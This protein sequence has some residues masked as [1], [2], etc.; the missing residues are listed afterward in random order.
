MHATIWKFRDKVSRGD[1]FKYGFSHFIRKLV[2]TKFWKNAILPSSN[3]SNY[4]TFSSFILADPTIQLS[5]SLFLIIIVNQF[6]IFF[7]PFKVKTLFSLLFSFFLKFFHKTFR[8]FVFLLFIYFFIFF[9][10]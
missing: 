3:V 5:R 6:Q 9:F 8:F 4:A 10:F 7:S 1:M 2:A